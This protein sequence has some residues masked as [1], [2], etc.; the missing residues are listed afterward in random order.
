MEPFNDAAPGPHVTAAIA[1]AHAASG[2]GVTVE[3]G[4][5]GTSLSGP[6]SVIPAVTEAIVGAAMDNGATRVSLQIT[7]SI[8]SDALT[9]K[10]SA[11]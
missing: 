11:P 8:P 3:V 1:A 4:P 7:E 5:F 2:L 6:S 10:D 9:D